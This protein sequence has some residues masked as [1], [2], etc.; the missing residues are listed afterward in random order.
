MEEEIDSLMKGGCHVTEWKNVIESNYNYWLA[1]IFRII[2]T[3]N[4]ANLNYK[5]TNL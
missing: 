2:L 3:G 5:A 1:V 4:L